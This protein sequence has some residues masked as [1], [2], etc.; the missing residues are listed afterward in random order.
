MLSEFVS[1][2]V[3]DQAIEIERMNGLLINLSD[4]PRAGLMAGLFTAE[5]AISNMELVASLRKPVGFY[6]P[7]NPAMKKAKDPS[8]EEEEEKSIEAASAEGRSPMLS[9]SNTDMAFKDNVMVAGS[10]HGFN[11][12]ELADNGIP[13]LVSSIICPYILLPYKL[14]HK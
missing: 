7:K 4:D 2:L 1:D 10:Y 13:S 9:F 14:I 12:Y 3:N 6:D 8:E 5:E 11:I